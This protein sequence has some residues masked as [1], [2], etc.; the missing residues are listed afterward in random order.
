[1][2]K[3]KTLDEFIEIATETFLEIVDTIEKY[4]HVALI[5]IEIE[6][7]V[8]KLTILDD[9]Q[10]VINKHNNYRQ[11]WL[12]SPVSGPSHFDYVEGVWMNQDKISLSALLTKELSQFINKIKFD[13]CTKI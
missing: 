9:K 4:D 8:L 7:D 12:S 11:I 13:L 6:S 1:M 10:Y 5:D 2:N 3:I